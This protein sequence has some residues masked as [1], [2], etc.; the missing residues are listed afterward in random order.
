MRQITIIS[1]TGITAPFTVEVCDIFQNNCIVIGS[2]LSGTTIPPS[3]T[4]GLPS[5]LDSVP[6]ITLKI[7]TENCITIRELSCNQFVCDIAYII[8]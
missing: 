2:F 5:I 4:L 7:T 6:I 3:I 8:I 1:T